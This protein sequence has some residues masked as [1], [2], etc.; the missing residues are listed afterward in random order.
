MEEDSRGKIWGGQNGWDVQVPNARQ[1][2][3]WRG[4]MLVKEIF[5]DHTRY[6]AGKGGLIRKNLK[7]L[8]LH[9]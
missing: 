8:S 9:R 3:W 4:I 7:Y 1:S 6:W 2:A 5:S